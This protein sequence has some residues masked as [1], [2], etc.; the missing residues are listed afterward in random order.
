MLFSV[1]VIFSCS[2]EDEVKRNQAPQCEAIVSPASG[3]APLEV[4]FSS[5]ARDTDGF[6]AK[7]EWDFQGDGTY[8]FSSTATGSTT[9]TYQEPGTYSATL[10]VTDDKGMTSISSQT[11][12]TME[13]VYKYDGF[14][15]MELAVGDYWK[16]EWTYES[17]TNGSSNA[18]KS[19]FTTIKLVEKI[20]VNF[21]TIG[22]LTLYKTEYSSSG[23][24]FPL[25]WYGRPYIAVQKGVI[26]IAQVQ[27]GQWVAVELL[28][29][30]TGNFLADQGFIGALSKNR[31]E[32]ITS[33]F[34]SNEFNSAY[35]SAGVVISQPDYKPQCETIAGVQICD[36]TFRDFQ[37]KEYYVGGI[38]FVGYYRS[39]TFIYSGSGYGT[40]SKSTLKVW[41]VDTNI[42]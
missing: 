11:V 39:G 26:Y 8:D 34:I 22:D 3:Y 10:R 27:N 12:T 4:T 40:I 7:Y 21:T 31:S 38:G 41:L 1:I 17:T 15:D 29:S 5:T 2:D 23:H 30:Q 14:K 19:G 13:T 33:S 20:I 25:T 18:R 6:I 16:Y 37:V 28:N 24:N 35:S 9:F 42:K 32:T 36:D